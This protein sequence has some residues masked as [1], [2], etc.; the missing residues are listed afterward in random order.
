LQ[1]KDAEEAGYEDEVIA[2]GKIEVLIICDVVTSCN[3]TDD[4]VE[5]Y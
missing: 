1:I 4:H 5:D 3:C 2:E